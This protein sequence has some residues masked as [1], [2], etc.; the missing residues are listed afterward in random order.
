MSKLFK[1]LRKNLMS[2]EGMKA[3]ANFASAMG[4]YQK[5]QDKKTAEK[6][7]PLSEDKS[8]KLDPE[9]SKDLFKKGKNKS[10]TMSNDLGS[11]GSRDYR[12]TLKNTDKFFGY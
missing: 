8:S 3:L 2:E 5:A 4:E 11:F 12:S 1:R 6:D 7:K 10:F 9:K